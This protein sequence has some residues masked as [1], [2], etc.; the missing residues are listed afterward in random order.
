LYCLSWDND[1]RRR[2]CT[3][4]SRFNLHSDDKSGYGNCNS[5]HWY[6]LQC[7]FGKI[8]GNC[9][10]N[11]FCR[12]IKGLRL[13]TQYQVLQGYEYRSSSCGNWDDCLS[14]DCNSCEPDY[15]MLQ[16]VAMCCRRVFIDCKLSYKMRC[17]SCQHE[18]FTRIFARRCLS[19]N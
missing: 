13:V 3:T 15:S 8:S 4:S 12:D 7:A 2:V 10:D 16:A 1:S 11:R 18:S 17:L 19:G 5:R 6:L 14:F 9:D